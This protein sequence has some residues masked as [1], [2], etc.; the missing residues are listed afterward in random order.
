[1]SRCL[2]YFSNDGKKR[3][4]SLL[5][6]QA[7]RAVRSR[8]DFTELKGIEV[9]ILYPKGKVSQIQEL[10]LTTLRR[11]CNYIGIT[12]TSTTARR[13]AKRALA[14]AIAI[15]VPYHL[16]KL[17]QYRP[18]AAAAVLLLFA[19]KNGTARRP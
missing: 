11:K 6:R 10:Q 9:V 8:P 18:L 12:G 14:D 1:M 5:R 4:W 7:I 2:Q 17:D 3:L 13:L 15:G 19:L 16:G